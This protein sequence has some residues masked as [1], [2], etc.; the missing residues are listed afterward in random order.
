MQMRAVLANHPGFTCTWI[1]SLTQI[2]PL[3]YLD[4]IE[5]SLIGGWIRALLSEGI[6]DELLSGTH[7][8]QLLRLAPTIA[9]Q[10]VTACSMGV[11]D[12]ETLKDGCSYMTQEMLSFI[13]PSVV[14]SLAEEMRR[15]GYVTSQLIPT[16]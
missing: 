6:S 13:I 8:Q 15:N 5:K 12:L 4:D 9:Y 10:L 11:I 7:P 3:G 16:C 14:I 2:H 1:S